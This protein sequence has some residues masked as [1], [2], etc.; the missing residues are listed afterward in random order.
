MPG[1]DFT[2]DDGD[3]LQAASMNAL[4][5]HEVAGPTS[6]STITSPDPDALVYLAPGDSMTFQKRFNSTSLRIDMSTAITSSAASTLAIFGVQINS[7]Y[8]VG[9]FRGIGG[10]YFASGFDA[11]ETVSGVLLASGVP[12]A[13]LT[14]TA[15]V[16]RSA[17]AGTL[18]LA[19]G[20]PFFLAV[21]E[22][23]G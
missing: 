5:R 10:I 1:L 20:N 8:N 21:R 11:P 12:A 22:V 19:A 13:T 18:T 16:Y 23:R 7:E 14:I 4:A 3:P 15:I 17:G 2:N 6:A 9:Q